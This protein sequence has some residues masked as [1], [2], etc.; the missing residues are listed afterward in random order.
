MAMLKRKLVRGINEKNVTRHTRH[1]L[2]YF[3]QKHNNN[4][5]ANLDLTQCQ[6]LECV[7]IHV[8]SLKFNKTFEISLKSVKNFVNI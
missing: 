8:F 7:I 4:T 5:S 1:N 3:E 6:N 2:T